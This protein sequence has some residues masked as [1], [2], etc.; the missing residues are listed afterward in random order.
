MMKNILLLLVFVLAGCTSTTLPPTTA[1][2]PLSDSMKIIEAAA[3]AAPKGVVGE[4][5]L[6]IVAAGS[7]GHFVYLNTEADYRD[8]RAVTVAL[9]PP[10]IKQLTAYYKMPPQEFFI[11]KKIVVRGKAQ[12]VKIAFLSEGK[13]TDKYYYQ[14]HIRL[15]D[16]AQLTVVDEHA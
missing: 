2:Y 15:M 16:I 1:T 13:R 4:Y 9:P 11:G 7:Q 6:R 12:R 3:N 8:Q 10:V 14:T 5:T